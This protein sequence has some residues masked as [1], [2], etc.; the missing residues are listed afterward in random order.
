MTRGMKLRKLPLT[1]RM[2]AR[3]AP[4]FP[5]APCCEVE[6]QD[7]KDEIHGSEGYVALTHRRCALVASGLSHHADD[8]KGGQDD[9]QG[10][11]DKDDGDGHDLATVLKSGS[12]REAH[13]VNGLVSLE[14]ATDEDPERGEAQEPEPIAQ[15]P[16]A[17]TELP[18]C[19][20]GF[21]ACQED[22]P[23]QEPPARRD[24]GLAEVT[25]SAKSDQARK[26]APKEALRAAPNAI[27]GFRLHGFE[28]YLG[29]HSAAGAEGHT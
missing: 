9:R 18:E 5:D 16:G 2:G 19:Q 3:P 27:A 8:C 14:G 4:E 1:G 24:G 11:E 20:D 15:V 22:R 26:A 6:D 28:R 7:R 29:P 12:G 21:E 25:Q 17:Q 23:K 13:V 10:Y